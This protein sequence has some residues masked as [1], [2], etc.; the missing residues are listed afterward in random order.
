MECPKCGSAK[1]NDL[2]F[3]L[4]CEECGELVSLPRGD[5]RAVQFLVQRYGHPTEENHPGQD[6]IFVSE[7]IDFSAANEDS[8]GGYGEGEL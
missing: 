3:T 8:S 5:V 7:E 1:F 6:I 4:E 2:L